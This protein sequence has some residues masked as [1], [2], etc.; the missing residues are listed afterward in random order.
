MKNS[1]VIVGM[2]GGV[3][4]SAALWMLHEQG[5][6]V[7]GV[8]LRFYCY[9]RARGGARP[10][11]SGASLRR[12]RQLCARL[13][14]PHHTVDVEEEFTRHVVRNFIDEYRAGRTPN[15]CVV[16][17]EKVKFPQLAR[18]ADNLGCGRIA[19]G[20]YA[21]LVRGTGGRVFLASAL[22]GKKD[23]SYFLYRVPVKLLARAI[24]PLGRLT[25]ESVKAAASRSGF[26]RDGERESQ[27]ICFIP[28]GAVRDF[29]REHIGAA[30]GEVVDEGGRVLG[31]HEGAHF[32]TIGQRKGLGIAGGERLHVAAIDI[33]SNRI[34]LAPKE[35]VFGSLALCGGLKLRSGVLEP[36]AAARRGGADL[37]RG[38]LFAKI[39]YRRPAAEVLRLERRDGLLAVEFREPQWAIT[40]GQSLVLYRG[41]VVVGGGVI[42]EGSGVRR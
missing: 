2:S 26:R 30:R 15:P 18:V 19:T 28:D 22:D 3:D 27:D 6:R 35:R 4:S 37:L 10:C 11:C 32:Y 23:Q 24:F 12:A 33:R 9:A 14:V 25:K 38:P 17:N 16:C 8:T 5:F 29:L 21:T 40:P 13:G 20:H 41:G 34:T 36:D 42:G 1:G 39:R 31:A 7:I